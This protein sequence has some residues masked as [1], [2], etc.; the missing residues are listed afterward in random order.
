MGAEDELGWDPGVERWAYDGDHVLPGSLRALTPPWDRCVHAEVVSLPRTDAELARARRVLTGLLDDPPRPVPRAPAPGLLEHAWEWAG[1]EIRARLPH[2]ADVTWARV[3][4][5]AAELRPA[6]R[7]LEE[8]AL[9]H[10]EPTLLRL[11]ADWRTDVAG[12]VWTWLTLDPDPA[13]FSP[14]A[15]P[16]A[17]RSVT[18]RLESD[19][20]IAYLGAAGAGGSAAAVDA[21]TRL[22]EKPDGPA[23]WDDAE[24]ARDMLAEL[25]ASGR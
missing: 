14:W 25:R 1:T 24:T 11:I 21:L 5:L 20:A 2:P 19:E 16:L 23:T 15:V 3:A 10:L 6:A 4:E 22:A 9:T 12:S 7:P 13:R 8:H 17:E 18:E